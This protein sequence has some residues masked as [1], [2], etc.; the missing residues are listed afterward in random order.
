MTRSTVQKGAETQTLDTAVVLT[1]TDLFSGTARV[2]QDSVGPVTS[3]GGLSLFLR[4]VLTLQRAGFSQV[5]ALVGN[6]EQALKRSVRGDSRVSCVIRWRPVR[7]FP[8]EDPL[9]WE[10]LASEVKGPCLVIGRQTVFSVALAERLRRDV[11]ESHIGLVL[12]TLGEHAD[13]EAAEQPVVKLREGHLLTFR[14]A[15]EEESSGA[16]QG[17]SVVADLVVLPS[18]MLRISGNAA[19]SHSTPLRAMIEQAVSD[20][21]VRPIRTS[22]DCSYWVESV[23]NPAEASRAER[24]LLQ[25]RKG[26]L[27]GFVDTYFNRKVSGALTRLFLKAGLS[28][29]AITALSMLIGLLAAGSF[30]LGSYGAG[31]LG[32]ILFQLSAIIDC[33][34]GEVARLTFRESQFGEQ[35]DITADNVVHAAIFAGI[36]WAVYFKDGAG[37]G[38]WLPLALGGAAMLAVG[39]SQWQVTRAKALQEKKVWS[40]PA[41]GARVQFILNNMATRD[42]SVL[43]LLFA[44]VDKLNWFLWL[45]AI[46]SNLFWLMMAWVTRPSTI[47]RA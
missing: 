15:L 8:P 39:L 40:H 3:V 36:A 4:T 26:E 2:A 29:N 20:G 9:T 14:D 10:A 38:S 34:D 21:Q 27:E 12:S 43:L 42:F 31:V 28:P 19:P 41:Q 24:A 32:A 11:H 37:S 35:L 13:Q 5:V 22:P 16:R 47:S 45:A 18:G 25:P 17:I 6:E 1:T 30:A 33:C 7:E 46:G 44:L 23:R